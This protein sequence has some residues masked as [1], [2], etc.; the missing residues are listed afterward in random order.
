MIFFFLLFKDVFRQKYQLNTVMTIITL[1]V[2]EYNLHRCW[3]GRS[4]PTV[5]NWHNNDD[6]YYF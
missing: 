5:W 4:S 6:C 1:E 3:F 2:L